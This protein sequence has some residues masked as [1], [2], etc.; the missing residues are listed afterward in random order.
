M[1]SC[2]FTTATANSRKDR[3]EMLRA[4]CL[5]QVAGKYLRQME[6]T[7][8]R[9]L[10]GWLGQDVA[11]FMSRAMQFFVEIGGYVLPRWRG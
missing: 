8:A 7:R 1:Y 3:R 10:P 6:S 2:K 9:L 5:A 4:D 11:D